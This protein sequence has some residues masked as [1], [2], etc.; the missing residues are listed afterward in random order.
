MYV[1]RNDLFDDD[2]NI[3]SSH[4]T[5]WAACEALIAAAKSEVLPVPSNDDRRGEPAT[6]AGA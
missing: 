3:V 2:G 4:P 1:Y 6:D 5:H